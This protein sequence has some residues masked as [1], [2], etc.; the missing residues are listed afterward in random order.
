MS[1]TEDV[2]TTPVLV[3][4]AT[5]PAMAAWRRRVLLAAGAAAA[6]PRSTRPIGLASLA[7]QAVFICGGLRLVRAPAV[8][9]R[10]LALSP[11]LAVFKL[12]LLA[13][14]RPQAWGQTRSRP[15]MRRS[16]SRRT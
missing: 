12:W 15:A 7:A 9:W 1:A 8:V 16:W 10:A 14:P 13:R 2:P 11:G 3:Q 6:L 4:E 5:R